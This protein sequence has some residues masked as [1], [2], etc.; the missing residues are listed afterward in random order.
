MVVLSDWQLLEKGSASW[1]WIVPHGWFHY[2]GYD[3]LLRYWLDYRFNL[4][5]G[6]EQFPSPLSPDRHWGP[7]YRLVTSWTAEGSEFESQ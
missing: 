4:R 2:G 5:Q 3:M 6:Q 1:S 7:L